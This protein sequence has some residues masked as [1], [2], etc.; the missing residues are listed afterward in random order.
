MLNMNIDTPGDIKALNQK[1]DSLLREGVHADAL[2][3][4]LKNE[5]A[6]ICAILD[7]NR[8]HLTRLSHEDSRAIGN[9][10]RCVREAINS[11]L[12]PQALSPLE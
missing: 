5:E 6:A 9:M 11:L 10:L 12:A 1:I 4:D 8:E 2:L 3:E 7:A